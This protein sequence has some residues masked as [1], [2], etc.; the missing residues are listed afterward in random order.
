LA[1][2]R[3]PFTR[4]PSR[5]NK[6]T[7]EYL[8][9]GL[10]NLEKEEDYIGSTAALLFS[11]L[12]KLIRPPHDRPY[13]LKTSTQKQVIATL[14]DWGLLDV[15]ARILLRL[16]STQ[17][18]F[19]VLR[20]ITLFY[21]ELA[22]TVPKSELAHYFRDCVPTWKKFNS[23]LTILGNLPVI[24]SKTPHMYFDMCT[25]TWN[26]ISA[27][28]GLALATRDHFGEDCYSS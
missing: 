27:S 9:S 16:G 22:S 12:L 14:R 19:L 5:C 23:Y 17:N 4:P 11:D 2:H 6:C 13:R 20:K 10:L 18:D 25:T 28:L 7:L 1:C 21:S 26:H 15:T 24:S 3:R 8:W